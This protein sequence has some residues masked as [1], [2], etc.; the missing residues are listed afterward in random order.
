MGDLEKVGNV[1]TVDVDALRD[2]RRPRL[3]AFICWQVFWY[4]L[5]TERNRWLAS[6]AGAAA[7]AA[8]HIYSVVPSVYDQF[9]LGLMSEAT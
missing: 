9:I 4:S 7:K 3:S 2:L 1:K 5:E 6:Y 8:Q